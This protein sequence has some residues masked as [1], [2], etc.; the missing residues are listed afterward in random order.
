VLA[1]WHC[2]LSNI[3]RVFNLSII[4]NHTKNYASIDIYFSI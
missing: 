3:S 2:R 1:I 4:N